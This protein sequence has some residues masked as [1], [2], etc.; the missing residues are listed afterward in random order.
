[1]RLR[2]NHSRIIIRIKLGSDEE[3]KCSEVLAPEL[4]YP[5]FPW[6]KLG[7][8]TGQF[9]SPALRPE[10]RAGLAR[11]RSR[12]EVFLGNRKSPRG[13]VAFDRWA[14]GNISSAVRS[15]RWKICPVSE[16]INNFINHVEKIVQFQKLFI[17]TMASSLQGKVWGKRG[18]SCL[19]SNGIRRRR[20]RLPQSLKGTKK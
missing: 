15:K 2:N 19:S 3:D 7:I 10:F 8:D 20:R 14:A 17:G 18:S 6:L 4:C 9:T 11:C 16:N 1:M 12:V 5:K 13:S